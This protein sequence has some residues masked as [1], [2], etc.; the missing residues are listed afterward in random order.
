M[1]GIVTRV[2][3]DGSGQCGVAV[4]VDYGGIGMNDSSK[5]RPATA[6]Y[7]QEANNEGHERNNSY[8]SGPDEGHDC[9]F[10]PNFRFYQEFMKGN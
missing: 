7:H 8:R 5:G 6:R 2:H 9:V 3:V 10:S 1:C 4:H